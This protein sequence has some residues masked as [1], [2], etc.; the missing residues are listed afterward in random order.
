[1]IAAR[2]RVAI[3]QSCPTPPFACSH[4]GASVAAEAVAGGARALVT[5]E[6]GIGNTTPAAALIAA[7]TGL[8][9][10]TVTGRG[11]GIDDARLA[12]KVGVVE[13][14]LA[15]FGDTT[16]VDDQ[17][18][19]C[20]ELATQLG[21]HVAE[22]YTDNSIS[23]WNKRV[24]RPGWLAMLEATLA[25]G[26]SRQTIMQRVKDGRLR[27]VHVRTGRRKGLRIEPPAAQDG[28]F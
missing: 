8:P 21:W 20:R 15:R 23:A 1:V 14:A 9:A 19:I 25:Y 13:R 22:V 18:R 6:M 27:A 3:T 26:V 16:K 11:T 17:E 12:L 10:A 28:L 4:V 7:C 24:K 2:G 5:G